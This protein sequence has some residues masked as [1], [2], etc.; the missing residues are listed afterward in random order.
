MSHFNGANDFEDLW[1]QYWHKKYTGRGNK[2]VP[3]MV[4]PNMADSNGQM[5]LESG[6]CAMSERFYTKYFDKIRHII[7]RQELRKFFEGVQ[8]EL[9]RDRTPV[10]N[11]STLWDICWYSNPYGSWR[12]LR[13][14]RN[15]P[16][17]LFSLSRHG[18]VCKVVN[19]GSEIIWKAN[20]GETG[21][22]AQAAESLNARLLPPPPPPPEN[23]PECCSPKPVDAVKLLLAT[24]NDVQPLPSD[25]L[26]HIGTYLSCKWCA[27][28]GGP[29]Y[30]CYIECPH[31]K[32]RKS[33][34]LVDHSGHSSPKLGD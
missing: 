19:Q 14:R 23:R 2:R 7:D 3:V 5:T 6:S 31:F 28:Y 25:V 10:Q 26:Y 4:P 13:A 29:S 22:N 20:G 30:C 24:L 16:Q 15:F 21:T 27:V 1:V 33:A 17:V 18:N 12:H 9:L 32:A 11:S 34:G 8:D